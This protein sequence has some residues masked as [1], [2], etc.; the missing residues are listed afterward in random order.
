MKC[1]QC[2][3]T[4]LSAIRCMSARDTSCY[5]ITCTECQ[6]RTKKVRASFN[7]RSVTSSTEDWSNVICIDPSRG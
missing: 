6:F 3:S 5:Q 2:G 7:G 1:E 4:K